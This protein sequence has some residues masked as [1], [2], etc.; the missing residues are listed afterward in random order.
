MEITSKGYVASSQWINTVNPHNF[1]LVDPTT[2]LPVLSSTTEVLEP[3]VM[4]VTQLV[5]GS[6]SLLTSVGTPLLWQWGSVELNDSDDFTWNDGA[7][8]TTTAVGAGRYEI[9]ASGGWDY[10]SGGS[11]LSITHK[12]LLNGVAVPGAAG[13]GYSRTSGDGGLGSALISPKILNLVEGDYLEIEV[14]RDQIVSQLVAI[15]GNWLLK[16]IAE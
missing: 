15:D 7:R 6:N 4:T 10:T 14:T 9:S 3:F 11:R 5:N 8:I 2:G 12:L 13:H 1:I 16:R